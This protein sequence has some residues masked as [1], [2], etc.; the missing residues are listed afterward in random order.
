MEQRLSTARRCSNPHN[1]VC[2]VVVVRRGRFFFCEVMLS[3]DQQNPGDPKRNRQKPQQHRQLQ[4]RRQRST[5]RVCQT[6]ACEVRAPRQPSFSAEPRAE[7]SMVTSPLTRPI[8]TLKGILFEYVSGVEDGSETICTR[9]REGHC[10]QR[11]ARRAY[12]T[13]RSIH[14]RLMSR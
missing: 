7:P 2:K 5:S 11:G 8:Q 1:S 9:C 14:T 13:W 10:F 4:R 12:G 3:V 6:E